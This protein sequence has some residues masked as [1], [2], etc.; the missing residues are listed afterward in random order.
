MKKRII[1]VLSVAVLSATAQGNNAKFK[2]EFSTNTWG[3][4]KSEKAA[5]EFLHNKETGNQAPGAL[6]IKIGLA[7]PLTEAFVFTKVFPAEPGKTY[8]ASV[9]VFGKSLA[10]AAQA[11]IAFQGQTA[12]CKFLGTGVQKTSLEGS[13]L[14]KWRPMSITFTIPSAGDWKNAGHLLCSLGVANATSGQIFFDDFTFS[15]ISPKDS[16]K[17]SFDS[18]AWAN[19]KSDEGIGKFLLN[20]E[21]GN[22]ALGAL[23]IKL[24]PNNP[25]K[26][27]FVF[28]KQFPVK[29]GKSY[30]FQVYVQGKNL[31]AVAEV[32]MSFQGQTADMKFLGTGVQGTK[33]I[34]ENIPSDEWKRMVFTFKIPETADWKN[35]GLVLCTLGISNAAS[36]QIFFDDFEFIEEE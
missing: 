33:L 15:E 10:P 6:E 1:V 27:G 31:P 24:G 17:G 20:T 11:S 13:E 22:K 34:G 12:E 29:S 7:N 5:G 9:Y 25:V 30:S 36:G 2:D 16:N 3:S 18:E 8:K 4:W 26:A 14:A 23:E 21:V 35:V 32:S 19:W 28:L